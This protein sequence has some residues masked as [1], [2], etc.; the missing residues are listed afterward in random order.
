MQ[1]ALIAGARPRKKRPASLGEGVLDGVMKFWGDVD[2]VTTPHELQGWSTD[3]MSIIPASS[4][5]ELATSSQK[6]LTPANG[7]NVSNFAPFGAGTSQRS[8]SQL[9]LG[10]KAGCESG[11][12]GSS[13]CE[14]RLLN[15]A[16]APGLC[17]CSE[18][19][20]VI[21]PRSSRV[22]QSKNN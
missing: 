13:I 14:G 10:G 20:F 8:K 9:R 6:I 22:T 2:G 11:I 4:A 3:Q 17:L 18:A 15:G 19:I 7:L 1:R 21:T 5:L 16:N 12:N